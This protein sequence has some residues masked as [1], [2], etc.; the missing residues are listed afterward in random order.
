M[1]ALDGSRRDF[2]DP[3]ELVPRDTEL[4][5]ELLEERDRE[6]EGER[7]EALPEGDG[8]RLPDPDLVFFFVLCSERRSLLLLVSVGVVL[9]PVSFA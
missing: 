3:V 7:D 9:Y 1:G 5:D 6:R 2:G 4:D 8:V